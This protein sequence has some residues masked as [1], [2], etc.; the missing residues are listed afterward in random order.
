VGVIT[1]KETDATSLYD[2]NPVPW[3]SQMLVELQM[4]LRK[5]SQGTTSDPIDGVSLSLL[6]STAE[7]G[8]SSFVTGGAPG[9]VFDQAASPVTSESRIYRM[10]M[11]TQNTTLYDPPAS[12][13]QGTD[14]LQP[15]PTII[16]RLTALEH[17]VPTQ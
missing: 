11:F 9:G 8:G 7:I 3:N 6:A 16:E 13:P 10:F 15:N 5:A 1:A 12:D 4:T 14:S 2:T 17:E